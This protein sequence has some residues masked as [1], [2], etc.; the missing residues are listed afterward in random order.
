MKKW[1]L[2][3]PYFPRHE[4]NLMQSEGAVELAR[5]RFLAD[6]FRNLEILLSSR[7]AWMK[8]YLREGQTVIELG[9]GAG[10]STLYLTPK[11]LL[12]DAV[13]NPWIDVTL[14]ATRMGLNDCSVDALIASHTI[15]HFYSPYT[16]LKEVDRVLK[17]GGVLLIQEINTA[18]LMRVLLRLMLHE[19]WSYDVDVFDPE[20]V[21]NDPQDLWSANCAVPELLFSQPEK[22]SETFTGLEIERNELCECTIFPLSG[23]VIAKTRVPELP[24]WLLNVAQGVDRILIALAPNLFALGR[25]VVIRKRVKSL[26]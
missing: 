10:F 17:P 21:V 18:L 8:N 15:H 3:K 6:R 19:G 13:K 26:G 9:A 25:R 11:P 16:F 12:T 22:F 20:A 24:R 2:S 7:Y 14:D 1:L 5:E 23:G 4:D